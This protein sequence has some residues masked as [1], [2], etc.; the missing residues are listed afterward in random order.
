MRKTGI[1]QA[2]VAAQMQHRNTCPARGADRGTALAETRGSITYKFGG[3]ALCALGGGIQCSMAAQHPHPP[4]LHAGGGRG[5]P[6]AVKGKVSE[7]IDQLAQAVIG[8]VSADQR[9]MAGQGLIPQHTHFQVT[10]DI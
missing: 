3:S 10:L 5:A 4:L 1:Q 6:A 9:R 2:W 8:R 7:C